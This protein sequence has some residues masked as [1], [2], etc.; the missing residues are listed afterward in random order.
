MD[1]NPQVSE[2]LTD[3]ETYV[4]SFKDHGSAW[5]RALELSGNGRP[6]GMR[7]DVTTGQYVVFLAG[8]AQ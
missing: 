4:G 1:T 7:F 5:W 6:A 2:V 3:A 8:G